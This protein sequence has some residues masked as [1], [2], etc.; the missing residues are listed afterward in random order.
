MGRQTI[1]TPATTKKKKRPDLK[2][3]EKKEVT[4]KR[5]LQSKSGKDKQIASQ[6]HKRQKCDQRKKNR[7]CC[8]K[9]PALILSL[10]LFTFLSPVT[11][12]KKKER[13]ALLLSS[14]P[15]NKKGREKNNR[16]KDF[17][18]ALSR[19]GRKKRCDFCPFPRLLCPCSLR[20]TRSHLLKTLFLIFRC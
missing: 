14:D 19:L 2:R 3:K 17:V 12:R 8:K 15:E 13:K 1:N 9:F 16:I 10:F 18:F 20:S 11:P 6:T 7:T 5:G 4:E